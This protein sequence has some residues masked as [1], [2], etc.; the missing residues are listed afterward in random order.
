M[1][2]PLVK[3]EDLEVAQNILPFWAEN[4]YVW[5]WGVKLDDLPLD[6]P[7]VF[8]DFSGCDAF[9]WTPPAPNRLALQNEML[10]EFAFQ[11]VVGNYVQWGPGYK[12]VRGEQEVAELLC[13]CQPLGFPDWTREHF[14]KGRGYRNI[15]IGF[16]GNENSL[17]LVTADRYARC[18]PRD[19]DS[20]L[21]RTTKGR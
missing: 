5:T 17:V 1:S 8:I 10:S 9:G 3:L 21:R 19:K 15:A 6:D 13:T 4:Q 2:D 7:F 12:D 16:Y 14:E 18:K 20:F 11:M